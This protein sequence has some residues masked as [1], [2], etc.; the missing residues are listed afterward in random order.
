MTKK[1]SDTDFITQLVKRNERCSFSWRFYD[2]I[3]SNFV[4]NLNKT[5]DIIN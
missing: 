1:L 4:S 5:A 2:G 3:K